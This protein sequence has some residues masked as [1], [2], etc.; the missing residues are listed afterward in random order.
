M[1]NHDY[2]KLSYV[3][4][5]GD[6]ISFKNQVHNGVEIPNGSDNTT[7]KDEINHNNGLDQ[8]VND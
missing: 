1:T 3:K 6:Q 8:I 7:N 5:G 4:E 2:T